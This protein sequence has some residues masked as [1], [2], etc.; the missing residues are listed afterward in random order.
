MTALTRAI[1][2]N[3]LPAIEAAL[4]A[5]P[6]SAMLPEN[7]WLPLEWAQ[8]T[9]NL[10]TLMRVVRLLDAP[11]IDHRA[12]LLRYVRGIAGNHFGGGSITSTAEQ[13][14]EQAIEGSDP[15]PFSKEES[16]VHLAPDTK[17]DIAYFLRRAGIQSK[18][19]LRDTANAV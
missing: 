2:S 15:R 6:A 5:E 14:W 11:S 13:V 7:G 18:A 17:S 12:I 1:V 19:E 16:E 4:R 8:K 10:S 9:G 3:D